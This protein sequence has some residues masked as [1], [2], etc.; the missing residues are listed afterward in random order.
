MRLLGRFRGTFWRPW[1]QRPWGLN[2][3]YIRYDSY[4]KNIT[5]PD[6]HSLYLFVGI[7]ELIIKSGGKGKTHGH[8]SSSRLLLQS[9]IGLLAKKTALKILPWGDEELGVLPWLLPA[10][11][12]WHSATWSTAPKWPAYTSELSMEFSEQLRTNHNQSPTNQSL[13]VSPLV[14]PWFPLGFPLV[15]PWFPPMSAITYEA[16]SAVKSPFLSWWLRGLRGWKYTWAWAKVTIK[17]R[18]VEA[19]N[20][21]DQHR[22]CSRTV[23][24]PLGTHW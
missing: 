6:L 13:M 2:D 12:A 19:R 14:S 9:H 20:N 22:K 21:I 4:L 1:W 23:Q 16:W 11:T 18:R 17:N 3:A 5:Y 8:D 15:S 7:F 24:L 10:N